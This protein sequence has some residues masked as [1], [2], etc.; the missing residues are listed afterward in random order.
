MN[1]QFDNSYAKLPERFYSREQPT[2]VSD[3]R[4]VIVNQG[5]ARELGLELQGQSD[6]ALAALFSGNSL[7]DGAEPIAQA[8]SGHQFGY[9]NRLGDGR[10]HMLGELVTPDGRRVDIQFKGS[11]RTEYGRRGDGRAALGPMLREYILG[12]AMHELGIATTRGLAVVTS[13]EPVYRETVLPGAIFTR[14]A[15][16]HLRVGTF[17][18]LAASQDDEGLKQLAD[19][20]IARHYPELPASDQPYLGFLRS[21]MA[22]QIDLIVNWLRVGFIHGVMNT[23]NI[24]ISGETIDYGPCAFMDEYHPQTVFSSI[25]H[26][27]RYAY[28]NQAQIIK[29]NLARFAESLLPL[30]HENSD[31]AVAMAEQVLAEFDDAFQV[32]WLDMMRHKLGLP[33]ET[34][35][36]EDAALATDLLQWMQEQRADYTNTFRDLAEARLADSTIY[37]GEA[38]QQWCSRWR[39][40]R[41]RQ[42]EFAAESRAMMCRANPARIPRNHR[43]EAALSA[44]EQKGDFSVFHSLLVALAEPYEHQ[45][46]FAEFSEPPQPEQRVRQT[47]CGT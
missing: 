8:Y 1:W 16:S 5:L 30:L 9:F 11:G 36:E 13:G 17:Q 15:A 10:A 27:G 32:A 20:A 4:V 45:S 6:D 26:G 39:A 7:P 42:G 44:A 19:Y 21:V 34:E 46:Q 22:R 2:P 40:R 14:V 43:V 47:F 35:T 29:W 41:D 3:P 25:D 12:E 24:T 31:E 18:H 28:G 37:Q 23:D 38:F 33:G